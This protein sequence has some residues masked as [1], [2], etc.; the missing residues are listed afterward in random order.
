MASATR[1]GDRLGDALRDRHRHR[2]DGGDRHDPPRRLER[3]VARRDR[4][5]RLVEP[6]DLD[7]LDLV[8]PG[9]EDVHAQAGEQGPQQVDGVRRA[10]QRGRD[11]VEADDRQRGADQ[12]V[13]APEAPQHAQRP[14]RRSRGRPSHRD[15]GATHRRESYRPCG[16]MRADAGRLPRHRRRPALRRPA[17]LSRRRHGGPLLALHAAADRRRRGR[18]PRHQPRRAGASVG[19]GLAGG[20]SRRRRALGHAAR[21]VGGA[22]RPGDC[23]RATPSP[24]TSARC[25][26]TS[27]RTAA[28]SV[29]LR[30]P[31]AVAAAGL[32]RARAGAGACRA[33]ASTGTRGCCARGSAAARASATDAIDL[34]GAVA[35]AEKNWGAGGMPPAWWWGQ[36]HGFDRP[37]VCVAFAG[38]RAGLGPPA[39][40]RD[41]ARG[42]A[43]ATRSAASCAR[44]A[45]CASPSTSAAGGWPA[46][47]SRSRPTPTASPRTCC[48]YRS[49][50]SAGASTTGRR[51]TSPASLRVGVRRRGRTLYEGTSLLAGLERGRGHLG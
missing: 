2:R 19:D 49:R 36:A 34:D 12:R 17:R 30:R 39:G 38:G 50:T 46:A 14:R 24:P 18:H 11:H 45:R 16:S 28:S 32:R 3:Q 42:R 8:D 35:Y 15:R 20:A 40:H 31:A 37:D 13:R 1:D 22:A 51:S 5:P 44:C 29:A 6:V 26:S 25:A 23:A 43:S 10:A 7:V 21:R 41:G 48:P 27:A 4:Q 9:D 47:A 33:S